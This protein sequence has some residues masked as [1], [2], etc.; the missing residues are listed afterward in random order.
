M[1][2]RRHFTYANVT[3]TLALLLALGG[4]AAY[5]VDKINSRD[6]VNGSIRSVDLKNHKAVRGLT[7]SGTPSP[8]V[9]STN[10]PL[11]AKGSHR[12]RGVRAG[13]CIP[14]EAERVRSRLAR[15]RPPIASP[16]DCNW[17]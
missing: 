3:A 14:L 16:R 5:A 10:G 2:I 13:R 7:L 17:Q 1:K 15:S 6:V 8:D 4:G 11:R 12:L 9:R